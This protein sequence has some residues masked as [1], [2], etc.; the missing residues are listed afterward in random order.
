MKTPFSLLRHINQDDRW[1]TISNILS[2]IRILLV[3]VVIIG[4]IYHW[5]LFT[6]LLFVAAGITDLLDGYFAR[7]LHEQ[8]NLGKVL[9]PLADKIFLLASFVSL[10]FVGSPSFQV[11]WWFVAWVVIRECLI[12]VGS[13]VIIT[14]HEYPKVEPIIWGKLTTLFQMLFIAWLF[15]CRFMQWEPARTYDVL[16]IL[17]ALFSLLS[18]VQYLK[19]CLNYLFEGLAL[20]QKNKKL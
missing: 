3:P 18:F 1:L 16:L 19:K 10:A 12:I 6:F 14:T 2:I 9:D 15:I 8:T 20:S 13:Y 4:F 5:W 7:L 11:P 17:L